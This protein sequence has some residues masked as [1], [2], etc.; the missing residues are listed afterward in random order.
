MLNF[1]NML[2]QTG[3][4]AIL[5]N[6]PEESLIKV[7]DSLYEGGVRLAEITFDSTGTTSAQT[8]ASHIRAAAEHMADRMLIGA[9]TVITEEQLNAAK[10]AGASFIISP[11]TDAQLIMA[12]KELGLISLP[13]AMTVSEIVTAHRAGADYVKLFPA[14][15]FG[16]DYI[17]QVHGPLP[18]EKLLAVS[19]VGVEEVDAYV[20]AGVV[21]FGIGGAIANKKLCDEQRYDLICENAR[22]YVNAYRKARGEK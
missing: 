11:H 6:I 15:A 16:T 5:R 18:A 19:G 17:K 14:S 1:D 7:M 3:V 8:T 12:T 22:S 2:Q 4:I 21:G 10:I 9:G 13:G 20:K